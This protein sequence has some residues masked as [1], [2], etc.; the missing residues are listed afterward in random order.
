[1]E[2]CPLQALDKLL[3][4]GRHLSASLQYYTHAQVHLVC[5]QVGEA[6]LLQRIL[7]RSAGA[8]KDHSGVLTE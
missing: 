7:G 6:G 1:M 3:R 5:L 2:V 8:P 4:G